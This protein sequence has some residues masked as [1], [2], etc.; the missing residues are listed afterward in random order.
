MARRPLLFR[1]T[2]FFFCV[3][4]PFS[5]TAQSGTTSPAPPSPALTS[6]PPD[7]GA[8]ARALWTPIMET[9]SAQA[10]Q[11]GIPKSQWHSFMEACVKGN[12]AAPSWPVPAHIDGRNPVGAQ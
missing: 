5:A 11:K 6:T 10:K 4:L 12:G 2:G 3:L 9:C 1:F 8:A 7:H